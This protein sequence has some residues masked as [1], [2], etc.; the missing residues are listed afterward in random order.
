MEEG[1]FILSQRG[2]PQL[3]DK[4]GYI[5]NKERLFMA[6]TGVPRSYWDCGSRRKLECK[7]R[8]T[9]EGVYIVKYIGVHNHPPPEMPEQPLLNLTAILEQNMNF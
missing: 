8:R 7:A 2:K 5:Y 9:M 3:V 4:K 1:H 6:K